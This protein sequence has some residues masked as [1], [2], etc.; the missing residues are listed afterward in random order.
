MSID[1]TTQYMIL[2]S[3]GM[4]IL[5]VVVLFYYFYFKRDL[6]GK[7]ANTSNNVVRKSE[8][9]GESNEN[10]LDIQFSEANR[11]LVVYKD[12]FTKSAPWI[13]G[14]DIGIGKTIISQAQKAK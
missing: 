4:M 1:S 13:G 8:K 3:I 10:M 14:Y 12:M 11:P 2:C 6:G 9:E 7:D 5:G